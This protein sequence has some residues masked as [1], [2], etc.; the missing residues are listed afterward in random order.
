[1][2]DIIQR[3]K[4]FI[5]EVWSKE[6]SIKHFKDKGENYKVELI[7][8]LP[9]NEEIS[10]YKQGDWLD[11]CRGPHMVSTK[12]IGKA[13]KLMKVAGAYWRGDSSNAMLTRIYGT[14]WATEK[15]LEQHLLQI[16]EAEKRDHRK[17]GREMDLFHFQEEAPGAVFWHP[18]GWTLFPVS[19]THL[20]LPTSDLV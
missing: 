17:L 20:T 15:D 1:M 11:L 19:Y 14:A 6:E 8:D 10:I 12:Q 9:N 4:N 2:H 3:N 7:N 5:R 13:F 18:K 16:E